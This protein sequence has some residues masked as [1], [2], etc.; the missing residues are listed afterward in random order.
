LYKNCTM[1]GHEGSAKVQM[2]HDKR[3][4]Y[5]ITNSFKE[6]YGINVD[7]CEMEFKARF[8]KESGEDA[9]SMFSMAISADGKEIYTVTNPT[10]KYADHYRVQQP[11]FQVYNTA[12]G[13]EAKPVRTFLA[14]HQIYI[15]QIGR[16]HV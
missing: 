8:S 9:R 7:T 4:A 11:R 6:I 15:M 1:Q 2:R 14:P 3:T 16:A 12:D 10:Q 13:L 5:V